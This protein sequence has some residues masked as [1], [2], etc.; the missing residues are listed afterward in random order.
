MLSVDVYVLGDKG[1]TVATVAHAM[2]DID[3]I[4]YQKCRK[5]MLSSLVNGSS[6]DLFHLVPNC[7]VLLPDFYRAMLNYLEHSKRDYA[8]CP[9][10][11]VNKDNTTSEVSPGDRSFSIG[12]MIVKSWVVKELGLVNDL[13]QLKSRVISEYR[14][15]EVPHHLY[16]EM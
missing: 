2:R 9:C 5:N 4:Q 3:G 11:R 16:M 6:A 1:R 13:N 8:F 7:A 14:G 15:I 12:Q 10:L